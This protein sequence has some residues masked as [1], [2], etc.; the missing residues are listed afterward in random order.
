MTGILRILTVC[1]ITC[2]ILLGCT[3]AGVPVDQTGTTGDTTRTSNGTR[4]V[5]NHPH[6][7]WL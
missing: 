4:S 2:L 1:A 7:G 3:Q 5:I 6:S